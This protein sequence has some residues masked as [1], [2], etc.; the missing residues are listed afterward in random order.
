MLRTFESDKG[1][2][3]EIVNSLKHKIALKQTAI[4]SLMS[5]TSYG[6]V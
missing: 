2:S 4:G 6:F 1:L 3:F 5:S